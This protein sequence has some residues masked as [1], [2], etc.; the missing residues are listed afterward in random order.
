MSARKR[1]TKQDT[2]NEACALLKDVRW[3]ASWPGKTW[4]GKTAELMRERIDDFLRR[5]EERHG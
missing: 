5:A 3:F 4:P 2:I 1:K